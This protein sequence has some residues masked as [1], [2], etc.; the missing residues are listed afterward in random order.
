MNL[1]KIIIVDAAADIDKLKAMASQQRIQM[2]D[3][4]RKETLN[5]NELALRLGLPQST[6]ATHIN[7]LENAG[8]IATEKKKAKKGSQK[9]CRTAFSEMMV[10]F[11][12]EPNEKKDSIDVEMPIGIFTGWNVSSPCGLCSTENIIGFLDTPD[13]FLNPDRMKA[14]L[15]WCGEGFVEYQFPN[16][17]IYETRKVRKLEL[18][19]ELSSE[20]PGTNKNWLSDITLWINDVEVGFWTS[21]G[22]FGDRRGLFTPSW[23]KLEGSKYGLL[24]NYSVT[25]EGSFVDGVQISSLTLA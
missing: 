20:V 1:D 17:A 10:K 6:V 12:D 3:I 13:S 11:P 5:V 4:L 18:S 9:L 23:W 7:I 15:L 25:D 24:K 14:G 22:D 21:P 8:L 16:N 19:L 2:L